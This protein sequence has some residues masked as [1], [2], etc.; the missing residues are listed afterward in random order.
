MRVQVQ[1]AGQILSSY[2]N[3]QKEPGKLAALMRAEAKLLNTNMAQAFMKQTTAAQMAVDKLGA[4]GRAQRIFGT[5]LI[6]AGKQIQWTGR[7]MEYS[8][9]L[10]IVAAGAAVTKFAY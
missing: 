9:T 2:R 6:A 1:L 8:L 5:N 7:Q 10:Q 3:L 4:F